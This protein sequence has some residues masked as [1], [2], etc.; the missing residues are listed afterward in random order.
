MIYLKTEEEINL[1]KESA[2]VLGKAHAEVAQWV[3]PGITTK[4]L[5]TIAED[6]IRSFGGIPSFKGFNNFPASLCMSVNEVVVHGIP[7]N[8]ELKD[9]DIVSIDCGVKL[10]GFHSDSAYTYPVGEV[11]KEVMDL[12]TAT[13]KSLYKGIEQAVDGLRVGD[14]GFAVQHY[15]EQKGYTVVRELVGH[16]VGRELHEAPEVPNYGKR[17]KG[18]RL[19]EGMV[20][21]IEPMINLGTKSVMQEKDG[22]TIRTTDRKYSA[23]FE[24]TVV[25]RKGKAEILTTFDYI[26]QV[27]ANTSLMVEVK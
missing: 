12:L 25:V 24:H 17:G 26:E 5:D 10:N 13:K 21:A 18:L 20:L 15:C 9:G 22:W 11:S 1:I 14:I 2:Q 4:K 3:K 8:Y 16:G 7:G 23:H 27:T 6:Y 19:K